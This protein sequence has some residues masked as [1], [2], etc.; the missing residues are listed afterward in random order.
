MLVFFQD[1]KSK[2][3]SGL[4]VTH[5]DLPSTLRQ[6]Q[7]SLLPGEKDIKVT[8]LLQYDYDNHR[9]RKMATTT[10]LH[11]D[12]L[13][14]NISDSSTEEFTGTLNKIDQEIDLNSK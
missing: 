12:L 11:Y 3:E 5:N 9:Y 13:M 2:K 1:A 6:M 10:W 8:D 7:L 14:G 4:E